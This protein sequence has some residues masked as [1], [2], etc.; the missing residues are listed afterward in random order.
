MTATWRPRWG[1]W[2]VTRRV[3]GYEPETW[4]V[5]EPGGSPRRVR[6]VS[7]VAIRIAGADFDDLIGHVEDDGV[8]E[9]SARVT[10]IWS[11]DQLQVQRQGVPRASL[12]GR[13]CGFPAVS[14]SA[15]RV[16]ATS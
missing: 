8:V 15:G 12:F 14:D 1:A 10:G 6:P 11:G 4:L 9:G 5:A 13:R 16:V 3:T 2:S 7:P